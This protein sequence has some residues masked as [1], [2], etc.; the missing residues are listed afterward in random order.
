MLNQKMLSK[1]QKTKKFSESKRNF[2]EGFES[3]NGRRLF[4]EP[5]GSCLVHLI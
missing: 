4:P 1:K 5:E 2:I 3:E